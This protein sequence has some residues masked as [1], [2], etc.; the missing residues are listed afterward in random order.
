M[1]CGEVGG[2]V[3]VFKKFKHESWTDERRDFRTFCPSS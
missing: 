1:G 2:R 3:L